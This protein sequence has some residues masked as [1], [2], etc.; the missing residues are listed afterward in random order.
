MAKYTKAQ[1]KHWYDVYEA[2][3]K[4]RGTWVR[5]VKPK[6]KDPKTVFQQQFVAG[7]MHL[8]QRRAIRR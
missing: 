5:W 6:K 3:P 1:L 8:S 4:A 2:L 7:N